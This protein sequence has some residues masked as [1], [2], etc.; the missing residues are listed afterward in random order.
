VKRAGPQVTDWRAFG[1]ILHDSG[2]TVQAVRD[3]LKIND[4]IETILADIARYSLFYLKRL[5]RVNSEIAAIARLFLFCGSVDTF[6]WNFLRPELRTLLHQLELVKPDD[7]SSEAVRG[8]IAVTEYKGKYFCSDRLFEHMGNRFELSPPEGACMPL[9]ASSLELL[10]SLKKPADAESFLDVGCGTGCQSIS[11]AREYSR[12]FGFDSNPRCIEYAAMNSQL[13]DIN[14]TYAKSDWEVF[15]DSGDTYH[16]V[17]YNAPHAQSAFDFIANGCP[18]ILDRDGIA[19]IWTTFEVH[20]ADG[21]MTKAL[22]RRLRLPDSLELV[23]VDSNPSSP[24]ALSRQDI[25]ERRLPVRYLKV[26]GSVT[27]QDYIDRL[28]EHEVIEIASVTLNLRRR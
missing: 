24:F 9:H 13:N 15:A 6:T 5:E 28:A 10:R 17:A 2:Y 18:R 27:R 19:Q 12:V 20:A 3:M 7:R 4:P 26:P 23:E 1:E 21:N 14:V 8:A 16:H 11:F 25:D 22:E